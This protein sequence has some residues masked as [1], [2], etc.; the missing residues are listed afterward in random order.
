MYDLIRDE[1]ES[2]SEQIRI[3]EESGKNKKKYMYI[4]AIIIIIKQSEILTKV[5][6][7]KCKSCS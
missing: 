4:I 6:H 7:E 2:T 3:K 5:I 1:I